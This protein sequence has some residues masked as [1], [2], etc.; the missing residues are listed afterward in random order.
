[1]MNHGT[2]VKMKLYCFNIQL[3]CKFGRHAHKKRLI[4]ARTSVTTV[5]L[6]AQIKWKEV[7]ITRVSLSQWS[8]NF[9]TS[10]IFQGVFR[11][12]SSLLTNYWNSREGGQAS[13]LRNSKPT[14]IHVFNSTKSSPTAEKWFIWMWLKIKSRHAADYPVLWQM[15]AT[16]VFKFAPF[17]L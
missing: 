9:K 15:T 6:T 12:S 8:A 7:E 3:R 13:V 1:M 5:L 17:L 14:I 11:F 10:R 4:G 2:N 16:S